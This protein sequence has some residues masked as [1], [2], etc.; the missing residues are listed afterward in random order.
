LTAPAI[1][2]DNVEE[3]YAVMTDKELYLVFDA[4]VIVDW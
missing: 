4:V 2:V 1:P 3:G